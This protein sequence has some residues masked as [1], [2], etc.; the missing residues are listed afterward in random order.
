MP[1]Q[2]KSEQIQKKKTER[3]NLKIHYEMKRAK[4]SATVKEMKDF[5]QSRMADD[6]L[7]YPVKDNPFREKKTCGIL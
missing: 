7:I 3:D 5:C 4:I 1:Y 2:N 6:P